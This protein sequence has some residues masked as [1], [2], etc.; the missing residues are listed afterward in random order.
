VLY[1]IIAISE[2]L[3][4]AFLVGGLAVRYGLGRRRAGNVLIA[5]AAASTVALLAAAAADLAGGGEAHLAHVIA[6][7]AVAYAVVYARHDLAIADRWV[8]RRLG[9]AAPELEVARSPKA[10]RPDESGAGHSGEAGRRAGS[11]PERDGWFRH[12]RMWAVG[13]VLL[14]GG[15]LI[16]GGID[17]AERLAGAAGVWTVIL[18]IDFAVSFSHTARPAVRQLRGS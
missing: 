5:G 12:L 10:K 2:V 8:Q 15:V 3:F 17:D 18:A 9:R 16:A 1:A 4:W 6:A 11:G 7:V 13:M 14:G